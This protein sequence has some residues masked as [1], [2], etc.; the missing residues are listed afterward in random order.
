M[1]PIKIEVI[2]DWPRSTN[3]T[4]VRSFLGLAGYCQRFIKGFSKIVVPLT[5]LTRKNTRFTLGEKQ[6]E[7]SQELKDKLTSAPVLVILSRT[8]GYVIYI[9]ASKLGLGCVLMTLG[10]VIAYTFRQLR[11]HEKNYPTYDLELAAIIFAH[12]IW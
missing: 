12:K 4:E 1:D 5:Q 3:V 8:E 2:K 11:N 6:K 7:S 10:K 9:D